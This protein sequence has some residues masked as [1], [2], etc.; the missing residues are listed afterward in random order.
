MVCGAPSSKIC[1]LAITCGLRAKVQPA[2]AAPTSR[3]WLATEPQ[4]GTAP[5][6]L[7][8]GST[9]GLTPDLFQLR[10]KGVVW[11]ELVKCSLPVLVTPTDGRQV[12]AKWSEVRRAVA[13]IL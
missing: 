1:A 5:Q 2:N 10:R 6:N 3:K 13:K 7:E 12:S 11:L 8:D 9:G 4:S